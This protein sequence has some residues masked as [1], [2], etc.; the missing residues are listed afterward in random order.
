MAAVDRARRRRARRRRAH[1]IND[2]RGRNPAVGAARLRRTARRRDRRG[3]AAGTDRARGHAPRGVVPTG[4]GARRGGSRC[5]AS[6]SRR[7]SAAL[8]RSRPRTCRRSRS[9]AGPFG[10]I[11]LVGS[12]DGFASRLQTF[13]VARGLHLDVAT[14]RGCHPPGDRGSG[15]L[16]RS[17]RPASIEPAAPTSGSG[18]A[19]WTAA[20]PDGSSIRCRPTLASG[21]RSRPSSRGPPTANGSRSSPAARSPVGRGSSTRD[22]SPAGDVEAPDLGVL[23]GFAGDR[24]VTYGAC[25][26]WPCPIVSV[27]VRT[28]ARLTLD[29]SGGQAVVAADVRGRPARARDAAGDGSEPALAVARW[30]GGIRS[31]THPRRARPGTRPGALGC[32]DPPARRL[33]PAGSRPRVRRR[34]GRPPAAP[35][36]PGRH[37][38]SPR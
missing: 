5:A 14:E 11:V 13:D 38:R 17:M 15:R 28:G 7:A 12:D 35:P 32:R 27:D 31:R 10:G 26:G 29:A 1:R 36:H 22:G 9:R 16:R 30:R 20:R 19:R 23:V 25:R 37:G 8:G 4:P 3:K 21:E 2:A 33:G 6:G 18:S 24:A 34:A